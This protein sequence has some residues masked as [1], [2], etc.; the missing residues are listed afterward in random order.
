MIPIHPPTRPA[1]RKTATPWGRPSCLNWHSDA[2]QR[3]R[4]IACCAQ[5]NDDHRNNVLTARPV[6]VF[7]SLLRIGSG[8]KQ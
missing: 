8:Q 2:D 4:R 5:R 1:K 3:R 6:Q 7:D